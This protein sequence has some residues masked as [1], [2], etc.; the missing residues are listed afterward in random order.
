MLE[1]GDRIPDVTLFDEHVQP[2]RLPDLAA[3]GPL[4]LAFYLYDWTRT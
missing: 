1:A 4:L 3:E 2:V